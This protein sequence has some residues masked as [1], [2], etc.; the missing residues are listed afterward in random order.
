MN[1]QK[2]KQIRLERVFVA[3]V[4]LTVCIVP[5]TAGGLTDSTL[6]VGI[7]Q[8]L[9]DVSSFLMILCPIAGGAAAGYFAIRRS[10]SDEQDGKFWE[11]RIKTAIICG[12]GG[13]LTSAL[14]AVLSS[15]F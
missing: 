1:N 11:K 9:N 15:Y 12:V 4:M 10:M 13:C 6:A 8:L 5:A 7:K 14:I 3:L 2:K